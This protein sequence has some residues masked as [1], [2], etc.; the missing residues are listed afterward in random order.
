[1]KEPRAVCAW[2]YLSIEPIRPAAPKTDTDDG[3]VDT[4]GRAWLLR[5]IETRPA[6]QFKIWTP[7]AEPNSVMKSTVAVPHK[8]G[9][10]H[11][12]SHTPTPGCNGS[13][14]TSGLACLL[15][16]HH[17]DCLKH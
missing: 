14:S 9:R 8:F 17:Y 2:E 16:A 5:S 15:C 13:I 7:T 4:V 1:M 11:S 10:S 6:A 12:R 3:V